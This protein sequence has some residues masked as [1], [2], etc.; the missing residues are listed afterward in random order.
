MLRLDP[1]NDEVYSMLARAY[2]DKGAWAARHRAGG[3]GARDQRVERTG[4]SVGADARGNWRRGE[5]TRTRQIEL[6]AEARE[7][8]P[9]VS[10]ADELL[11]RP[12]RAAGVSLRRLRRRAAAP[13][14]IGKAPT[15]G[16]E[17]RDSS[18]SVSRKARLAIRCGRETYCVRALK[19]APDDPIAYFLLGNVNRDIFNSARASCDYL[20]DARASYARMLAINPDLDE[21]KNARNYL[22]QIDQ[23]LRNL[24]ARHRCP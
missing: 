10:Q 9:R 23:I 20:R 21:A 18:A 24:G 6:Y 2:W 22:G 16:S 11:E 15:R 8:Y 17:R 5:R 13:T 4:A 3:Q 14:P 1:N 7:E 19:Y 12:R